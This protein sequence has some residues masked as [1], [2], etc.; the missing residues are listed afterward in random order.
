MGGNGGVGKMGLA[1]FSS[2]GEHRGRASQP[3]CSLHQPSR[4]LLVS[5]GDATTRGLGLESPAGRE[6]EV[7]FIQKEKKAGWKKKIRTSSDK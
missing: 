5:H 3:Q 1:I 4:E 6:Y 7:S 2:G